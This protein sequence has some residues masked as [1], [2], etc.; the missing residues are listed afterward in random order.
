[1]IDQFYDV[2]V[3]QVFGC[4]DLITKSLV[5]LRIEHPLESKLALQLICGIYRPENVALATLAKTIPGLPAPS[6]EGCLCH[7]AQPFQ[8]WNVV[9][10]R[11]DRKL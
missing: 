9:T 2:G 11:F 1:M 6:I 3:R 10:T 4:V 5:P 7:A 8:Q